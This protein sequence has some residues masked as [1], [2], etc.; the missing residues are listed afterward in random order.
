MKQFIKDCLL[1]QHK[2]TQMQM[3]GVLAWIWIAGVAYFL[4][5]MLSK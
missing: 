2:D 4:R 5:W 1:F 3:I